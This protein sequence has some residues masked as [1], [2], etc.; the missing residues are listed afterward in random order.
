MSAWRT[1]LF[2]LVSYNCKSSVFNTQVLDLN[3][4]EGQTFRSPMG[5]LQLGCCG[6][7]GCFCATPLYSE[8]FLMNNELSNMKKTLL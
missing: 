8:Y 3:L 1:P 7:C 5:V 4:S 6:R 2:N